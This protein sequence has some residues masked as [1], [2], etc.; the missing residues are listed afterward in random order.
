MEQLIPKFRNGQDLVGDDARVNV[1][2]LALTPDEQPL[3]L[4]VPSFAIPLSTA[5][6]PICAARGGTI[7]CQPMPPTMIP[8]IWRS[9]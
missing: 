5:R 8:G 6:L 9:R 4:R 2:D 3:L 1:G 7:P